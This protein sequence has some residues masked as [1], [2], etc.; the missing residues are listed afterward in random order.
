MKI[1]TK[2]V[3]RKPLTTVLLSLLLVLSVL[4]SG[5][6]FASWISAQRQAKSIDDE[7]TTIAVPKGANFEKLSEAGT[8]VID[9]G[10]YTFSSGS[11]YVTPFSAEAVAKESEYYLR[12]D[13]RILFSAHIDG[14]S[15]LSSGTFDPLYYNADLDK[16]PYQLAVM[17]LRCN[18]VQVPDNLESSY[19]DRYYAEFEIIDDVCRIDAYDLPPY[20]DI[21]LV[22]TALRTSDGEMLFEAGK[23][24]L[25]QGIY[26]DYYIYGSFE[27]NE[28]GETETIRERDVNG[29]FVKRS[30][31][32]APENGLLNETTLPISNL[33]RKTSDSGRD[34]YYAPEG[35]WPHVTEY[36]G[37]WQDFL[38]TEE[39]SVWKKEIIPYY[40]MNHES[41]AV[42]LTDDLSGVY[43]FNCGAATVTEGS[44]FSDSDHENGN[45]VCLVSAA[46][47]QLNGL[48]V[49]DTINLDLYNS[50]YEQASYPVLQGSGRTGLTVRR[51][52]LSEGTRIGVQKDYTIVGIYSAPEWEA[53]S[54]SFH[55]DTIFIPKSS[56]PN[57]DSYAGKSIPLLNT[58]IIQNGFIDAFEA[59]M[60]E[61]DMAGVYTYFDQGYTEAAA[62]VQTMIDNAQRIMFIGI[63]MFIL[64]SLLFLLL[65]IRSSTPAIQTMRLLGVSS[66]KTWRECF[67]MLMLQVTTSV[68]LGNALAV[69][70]YD[71][72]AQMVLG[73]N[74]ELSLNSILLCGIIQFLLLLISGGMWTYSVAHRNLM[75]KG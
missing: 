42:I 73:G 57:A 47:A 22:S 27:E 59:H 66:K 16:Y 32:L 26:W 67:F 17:A 49:G 28:S 62:S 20:E 30:L 63:F 38:E 36:T 7:Y 8:H 40:Q 65:Y 56:V 2:Q 72:I 71:Q 4:V 43:Y 34:Y 41:A 35:S 19:F 54:Q 25:V 58:V 21:L 3:A 44:A 5:I 52:P 9:D 10:V 60:A 55:A 24:Y 61:N 11:T 64:S 74:L 75:Q 13:N 51:Y 53:G 33:T 6:G 50:G 46:Y 15:T 23:T 1:F 29:F 68:I 48:S 14:S 18:W 31:T 69:L 37:D 39:G 45:A 12:S 70:L